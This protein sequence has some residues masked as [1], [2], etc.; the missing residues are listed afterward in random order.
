MEP[1][2]KAQ[3]WHWEGDDLHLQLRVLPRAKRDALEAP[4]GEVLKVRIT[5][6]P[7][8]G[9]ANAHLRRFLAEQFGVSQSA[10]RIL[11]GERSRIKRVRIHR[12]KRLPVC[13]S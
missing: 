10:I 8:E 6:P 2:V 13:L 4:A 11:S 9:K 5:A 3:G 7:V 12:P 1:N